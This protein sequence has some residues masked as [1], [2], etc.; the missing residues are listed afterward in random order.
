ML[1]VFTDCP[2][3]LLHSFCASVA[4]GHCPNWLLHGDG[5]LR[6]T[7]ED[8]RWY[9]AGKI[10]PRRYEVG[11]TFEYHG[12]S[13]ATTSQLEARATMHGRLLELL[14]SS[15]LGNF[16]HVVFQPKPLP[17]LSA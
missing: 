3:E 13:N 15:F 6:Y 7:G 8:G 11:V 10:E 4:N 5:S 9:E 14:A 2:D 17:I 1:N 12:L 16:S